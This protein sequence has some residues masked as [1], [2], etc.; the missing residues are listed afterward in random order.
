MKATIK[1][2]NLT[3]EPNRTSKRKKDLA[4]L[5]KII[6]KTPTK[7]ELKEVSRIEAAE[8]N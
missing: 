6:E 7:K 3:T 2:T 1:K 4:K 8:R 5:T